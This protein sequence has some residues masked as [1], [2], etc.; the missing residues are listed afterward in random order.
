[1]LLCVII[2]A[3]HHPP[4]SKPHYSPLLLLC[5]QNIVG[6]GNRGSFLAPRQVIGQPSHGHPFCFIDC[7]A[8][9]EYAPHGHQCPSSAQV[10]PL[11]IGYPELC[12]QHHGA[13]IHCLAL[14]VAVRL[15]FGGYSQ[16]R[17]HGWPHQFVPCLTGGAANSQLVEVGD[18]VSGRAIVSLMVQGPGGWPPAVLCACPC[19]I[20]ISFMPKGMH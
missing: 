17:C 15:G 20:Y 1:M 12:C 5:A 19:Q 10:G 13:K 6:Q 3:A 18:G 9:C 4:R 2:Q 16:S 11:F 7:G 8:I 14:T